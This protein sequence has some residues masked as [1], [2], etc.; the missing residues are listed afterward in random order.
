MELWDV[1]EG[2]FSDKPG[3]PCGRGSLTSSILDVKNTVTH[4]DI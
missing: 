1:A 4:R 3:A 2:L